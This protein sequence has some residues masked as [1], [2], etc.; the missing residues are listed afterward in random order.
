MKR[1]LA[2]SCAFVL[3]VAACG[4]GSDSASDGEAGGS[5]TA[6]ETAEAG[7]TVASGG[8]PM[9]A[10]S[11]IGAFFDGGFDEAL[12]EYTTR[13][14]EQIVVCMAE[15]GF[16]FAVSDNGRVDEIELRQNE[17]TTREWTSEYGFG[18]ST[19]FDS[20]AQGQAGDPNAEIIFGLSEAERELW[21][22]TLTGGGLG[23]GGGDFGS[24]PLEE[25]GCIGRALIETGGQE[26]LEGLE[27]F[28]SV[29]DEGL[30]A[31]LDR[32]EMVEAV[33]AWS[34]CMS[35]AGYASFTD[36]DG[37]EDSIGDRYGD[38]IAPMQA[39]LANLSDEEGQALIS[40][41]SLDIADL[42]D[43][44]LDA[45]RELQQ[46][47]VMLA[48]ADL[49]CYEAEVQDVYEPLRDEYENGLLEEFSA[50]FEALRNIGG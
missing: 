18:I 17:L 47:E 11:P 5:A 26:A 44:D 3:L 28:G 1:L 48:L 30:E 2:C 42:P 16:E 10:S 38:V 4:S 21:I 37:P 39:A 40:G 33:D 50:E 29:Y 6:G 41:E 24:T 12:A 15:Q 25:Q 49:D 45:L 36:L 20:I 22:E 31:L 27:E 23:I 19:S 13:V 8:T 46:D 32:R 43:L 14:E 35:A 7:G 9:S 34:Q